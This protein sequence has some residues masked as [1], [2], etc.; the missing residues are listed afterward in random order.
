MVDANCCSHEMAQDQDVSAKLHD[1]MQFA[2]PNT[3]S[4][5]SQMT[6]HLKT[7]RSCNAQRICIAQ[8]STQ[9]RTRLKGSGHHGDTFKVR[10][11]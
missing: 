10:L 7:S 8:L 2:Q 11:L 3:L 1:L 4:T 6:V 5:K 9:R